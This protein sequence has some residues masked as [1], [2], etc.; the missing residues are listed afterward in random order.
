[1]IHGMLKATI[2]STS[3]FNGFFASMSD[4]FGYG[5]RE[6]EDWWDMNLPIF[7]FDTTVMT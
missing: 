5:L 6:P 4:A 1:M 7:G 2:A 3:I